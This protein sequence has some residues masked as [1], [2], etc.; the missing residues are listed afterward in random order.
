VVA[1]ASDDSARASLG[2]SSGSLSLITSLACDLA[3]VKIK[4]FTAR[5]LSREPRDIC[6]HKHVI[7]RRTAL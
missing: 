5:G 3:P 2:M 6:S 1:E 4:V 7:D